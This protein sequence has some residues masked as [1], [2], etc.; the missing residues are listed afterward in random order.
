MKFHIEVDDNQSREYFKSLPARVKKARDN[1]LLGLGLEAS[2]TAA[3]A[4]PYLTGNLR[5]SIHVR[6]DGNFPYLAPRRGQRVSQTKAPD[7]VSGEVW[8]GTNLSYAEKMEARHRTRS[9]FM[10]K[11][12]ESATS[13]AMRIFEF[14]FDKAGIK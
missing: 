13:K 7:R 2:G 1:A 4:A 5:R 12:F 6:Q 3:E 9:G 11:G 8:F 14:E 10:R